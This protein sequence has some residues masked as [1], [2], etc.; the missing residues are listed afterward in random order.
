MKA[1]EIP[2][3]TAESGTLFERVTRTLSLIVIAIMGTAISIGTFIL[4]ERSDLTRVRGLLEYSADWRTK[5]LEAKIQDA[6]DNAIVTAAYVSSLAAVDGAALERFVR[7]SHLSNDPTLSIAWAPRVSGSERTAFEAAAQASGLAGFRITEQGPDGGLVPAGARAEYFPVV[8]NIRFDIRSRPIGFDALSTDDRRDVAF[9]ARDSGTLVGTEPTP[10]IGSPVEQRPSFRVYAPVYA[11]DTLPTTAEDRRER[12]RGFVIGSFLVDRLLAEAI[13]ATPHIPET[14]SFFM[15]RSGDT[16]PISD[17]QVIAT[18]APDI[19]HIVAGDLTTLAPQETGGERLTRS[20]E[21]LGQRWTLVF[22]TSHALV[23]ELRSS[24]PYAWLVVGLTLTLFV[25]IYLLRERMRLAELAAKVE[26]RT[27][28]LSAVLDAAPIVL[29]THDLEGRVLTWNRAAERVTGYSAAEMI[30]RTYPIPDRTAW[31]AA[32]QERLAHAGAGETVHATRRRVQRKD[33]QYRDFIQSSGPIFHKGK[34]KAVVVAGEDITDRL[35][36]EDQLR[37]AQKMEA[38]GRLTGGIAHDFNNV[39]AVVLNC[40]TVLTWRL[41]DQQLELAEMCRQ[42]ARRGA[43]LT[44]RMMSYARQQSLEIEEI[45]VAAK[46][47]SMITLL[48]QTL[49]EEIEIEP[50]IAAEIPRARADAG[51]L[52]NAIINL[53]INAKDAMENGGTLTVEVAEARLDEAYCAV[54]ADAKP[55]RYV[56]VAIGDTGTG[57]AAEV[58]EKAFDPFFTTKDIGKGTGLGLSM[59]YGFVKQSDGHVKIYSEPGHGTAVKLYL[60]VAEEPRTAAPVETAATDKPL[61]TGSETI[62]VVEDDALLRASVVRQIR[63]LGYTV[64]EAGDGPAALARLAERPFD[65][66]FS[67]LVMPG[68]MSGIELASK[69]AAARPGIKI[70]LTSGYT[71]HAMVRNSRFPEGVRLLSKPYELQELAECLRGALESGNAA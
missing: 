43:A 29:A 8:V 71:E 70:L 15:T 12:M 32:L 58:A 69:A 27:A 18:Y 24:A 47:T 14:V 19:E 34:L 45:D 52:E 42:A 3:S 25:S 60:P 30:G 20:F 1:P 21:V 17:S 46:V 35:A 2:G 64:V 39:L 66:V 16:T 4:L 33:G 13:K 68:G 67:D 37:H 26:D 56:M 53:A 49:G 36:L 48:H 55:G 38:I 44:S 5:D 7:R 62:L 57:M 22:D 50:R 61:P 65:L 54:N 51:Q 6:T 41:K 31:S 63:D 23:S 9:R 28:E 40:S 59:V 11:G 10:L